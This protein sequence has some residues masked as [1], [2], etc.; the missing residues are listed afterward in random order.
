[1]G[2]KERFY[3][4]LMALHPEVTGSCN[5]V[6][7]KKPDGETTKFIVDCGMFQ[8]ANEHTEYNESFPFNP[9][10]IEFCVV[11]HNHV[12]HTGRLPLLVKKGFHGKFFMTEQTSL[13]IKPA[14]EDSYKVIKDLAKRN[15]KP[16]LYSDA[17]V[18]HALMLKKELTFSVT[19]EV[20]KNIKVTAFKNGH[21]VGAAFILVQI[22][23]PGYEDIN[24][25]FTGDY[26]SK[27]VFFDV[28]KLPDWVLELPLT[29]V[30]ESTYGTTE[31][32]EIKECFEK[33]I[34]KCMEDGGTAVNMVF[35]L[36]R[37]QEVLYKLKCMQEEEKISTDIPIFV[38][39]KLGNVYTRIYLD[40]SDVLEIR[41][42][43]RDFLPENLTFVC[44]DDREDVIMSEQKKIIVTTSGMGT[45]GPAP[46]YIIGYIRRK[47]SLIQFTGYTAEG[48]LGDRLKN[49]EVGETVKV[50]GV[51]FVK[52]ENWA[53]VEYT[54]EFSSHA[55]ANEMIAFLKNFKQPK[56]ILINHGQTDVKEEF[57]ERVIKELDPKYVGILGRDYFYRI[58]HYGL[59]R[60]MSTK[61]E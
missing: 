10:E 3:V 21:L 44:K 26:N 45:Y 27:N 19:E 55:K 30:Q 35:S 51:V 50:A 29:I 8:G 58:G 57:A 53:T 23:Y 59:I 12:D 40:H 38:D 7:V 15:H 42:D 56:L 54:T 4:D 41:E 24:I 32:T 49:A 34:L 31:S 46:Q 16:E 6:I 5:L 13:L 11:T 20:S 48:T 37:L 36:G 22:S 28:E 33:N 1:M 47:K 25:L 61:F 9:D 43:M 2:S 14:L 39:G 17:D 18:A 60:T 52:D